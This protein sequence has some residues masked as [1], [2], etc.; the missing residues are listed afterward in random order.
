LAENQGVIL[1]IDLGSVRVGV[2]A[3]DAGR[4]LA[5][6]LDTLPGGEDVARRVADLVADTGAVALVVGYP[7]ALDGSAGIAATK[8]EAQARE[9]AALVDVPVWLVDE[10][11]STAQAHR[12]LRASGRTAKTARSVI[13]AQS[14]VGI[15][16][17]VL[18]ASETGHALGRKLEMEE[19][20]G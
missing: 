12:R 7:L 1:A 14:A 16:E 11:M 4:V 3:C 18:R 19:A 20:N 2:A 10:R 13:D 8:I 5:Y 17:S 6:P 15:L 9:V